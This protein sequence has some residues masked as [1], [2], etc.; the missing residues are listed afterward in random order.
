MVRKQ[1]DSLLSF[2]TQH[3]GTE[4][5]TRMQDKPERHKLGV[6]GSTK[7]TGHRLCHTGSKSSAALFVM[8]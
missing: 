4:T 7:R 2:K 8:M 3:M 6:T 5:H 1:L